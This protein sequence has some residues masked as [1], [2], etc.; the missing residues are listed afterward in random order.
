MER[1]KILHI[2]GDSKFGGG[3]VIVLRLAQKAK[4]YGWHVDVLTTDPIFKKI[5]EENDMG[6]ID[7]EVIWRDINPPKD[8]WGLY[9]LY[10]FLKNSDYT[11]VHTHTSKGGFIGRLAAYLAKIPII[12]HTVHGFAF[13]EQSSPFKIYFFSFLERLAS[14]WCDRIVTVSEFHRDWALKLGIGS[15]EKVIAI[16]NGIP[17]ERVLPK[18]S[19]EEIRRELGLDKEIVILFTG[20]LAPQK[21]VEY[22]IKAV[23]ILSSKI[24]IPFKILLVGEGPLR[25]YLEELVKNLNIEQYV[26]FLGFRKDIENLLS[27]SNIVV[28]PSL[29]EGLSIALL[30]AM[31]A[32]KPIVTT[33]IGSNL[34]VVKGGLSAL[35]VPPKDSGALANAIIKLIE[36]PELASRLAREAKERYEKYYTEDLMLERYMDLYSFLYN[37]KIKRNGER[38]NKKS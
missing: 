15:K 22:L 6:V 24:N 21:G 12:I 3:S 26:K 8:L 13:H 5:L 37:I 18:R 17:E 36:N 29:W 7:L 35:L 2:L 33:T 27:I 20:R 31:A 30:E 14:H 28:L 9:K 34:E 11:I 32:E 23:P 4:E 19:K 25:S 1:L 38:K 16:P 10:K